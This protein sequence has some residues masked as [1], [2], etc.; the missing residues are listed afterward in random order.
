[1]S[2]IN[3]AMTCAGGRWI[4][5]ERL[6]D[7]ELTE[8]IKLAEQYAADPDEDST[9]YFGAAVFD[10]RDVRM[11]LSACER[12]RDEARAAT[13]RLNDSLGALALENAALRDGVAL[14]REALDDVREFIAE[15][16]E[17]GDPD[18]PSCVTNKYRAAYK[19]LLRA[20]LASDAA[21]TGGSSA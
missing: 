14:L 5:S 15:D 17:D 4:V 2:E 9:P 6:N 11:K 10:L 1:M 19:R 18:A 20:L 3:D 21:Q 13:G 16:F 7:E 12:E 8:W